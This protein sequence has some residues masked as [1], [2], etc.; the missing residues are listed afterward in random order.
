M[1]YEILL[2]DLDDTLLDF[3]AN[4]E[5]A[6]KKLFTGFGH[7][8]NDRILSVYNTVNKTLWAAYEKGDISLR[9]VLDHRFSDTMEQLGLYI[10]GAL[11]EEEYRRL[12]ALG[13]QTMPDAIEVCRSLS[14]EHRLFIITNGITET[15]LARIEGAGLGQFFERIFISQQLGFQ[16]PSREFFEAVADG[17]S[18]FQK[19]KAMVVGD[20]LSSDIKGGVDFGVD[21]CLF[22]PN[23]TEGSETGGS[24]YVI[25][26]LKELPAIAAAA[27]RPGQHIDC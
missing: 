10:N 17:I 7:S 11:W 8:Y 12:L 24:T 25:K 9:Q 13:F 6:L 26:T 21:T 2:M 14:A 18:G 19:E 15:Q 22:S 23:Y 27:H 20:S 3:G 1:K 16:K 4:E 5:Q